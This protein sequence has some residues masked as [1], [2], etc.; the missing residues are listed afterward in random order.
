MSVQ[1]PTRSI[2]KFLYEENLQQQQGHDPNNVLVF[3]P[4]NPVNVKITKEEVQQ[5]LT[6]YGLPPVVHNLALYRRAF[7]H[8]S[9]TR[10]PDSENEMYNIKIVD[11]PANCLPLS[12]KSNE[13]MEYIGDG[14]LENVT[15]CYLYKRFSKVDEGFMTD[16]KIAIVKN[17]HI[18]RVALEMGLNKWFI[19]SRHAEEKHNRTNIRKLSC[20]FEAFVGAIFLDMNKIPH[21]N[22]EYMEYEL[23]GLGFQMAQRFIIHVLEKHIDW[24][25]LIAN[26]DNFK[27]ILQVKIQKE[28]KVTPD[29]LILHTDIER[30]YQMG[31]Y[32]CVGQNIHNATNPL[33]IEQFKTLEEIHQYIAENNGQIFL[34]LS[35]GEHKIK[36]KAEQ[37]AC[38]CALQLPFFS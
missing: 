13:R 2:S 27:N 7:V 24:T 38:Q 3:N 31:L 1:P 30:G 22:E 20:L 29:Y 18:G 16:K 12:T 37:I 10:R 19:I 14:I 8:K 11:Q 15:K 34:Q 9:Y 21:A 6:M 35:L 26:D 28:F 25:K 17:E 33:P 36:R 5:I 32:L 23:D 4:F